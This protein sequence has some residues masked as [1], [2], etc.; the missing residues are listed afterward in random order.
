MHKNRDACS[1]HRA[2]KRDVRMTQAGE[3]FERSVGALASQDETGLT[4]LQMVL[5]ETLGGLPTSQRSIVE[6]RIEGFQVEEI[7]QKTGRSRRT[8]ERALQDFRS[9][10]GAL[11][12]E[13]N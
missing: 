8:V 7:A 1:F 13:D 6:L 4:E 9:Q 12:R 11:L 10:L 2:A 5:E 3:V